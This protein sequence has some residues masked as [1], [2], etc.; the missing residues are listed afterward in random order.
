MVDECSPE[1]FDEELTFFEVMQKAQSSIAASMM[2]PKVADELTDFAKT[3][4]EKCVELGPTY[5][6]DLN[7]VQKHIS[8][9]DMAHAHMVLADIMKRQHEQMR[10]QFIECAKQCARR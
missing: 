6:D 1:A 3:W 10:S 4:L 7:L 2:F 9:K 8:R 5:Q